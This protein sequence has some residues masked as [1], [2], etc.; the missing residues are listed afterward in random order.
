MERLKPGAGEG[1][2]QVSL[3]YPD[4]V[5]F[6]ENARRR[7]LREQLESREWN[8]AVA[9]NRPVL[10]EA[11][12]VRRQIAHLLGYPSWAHYAMKVR[13]AREPSAVR[14]FYDAM[15]ESQSIRARREIDRVLGRG[16]YD[17]AMR[18]E[19]PGEH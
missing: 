13:M 8:K 19:W 15:I 12:A 14:R 7:D 11:L 17:R 10:V 4:V 1:T 9:A 3:D 6:M 18:G 2:Y 16:A 5:P